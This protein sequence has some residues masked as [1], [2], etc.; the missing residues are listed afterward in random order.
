VRNQ[1]INLPVPPAINQDTVAWPSGNIL[2]DSAMTGV[3]AEAIRAALD[4]AFNENDKERP[5]NTL[6]VL[7][8]YRGQIIA[9]RYADGFNHNSMFMG[10]SMTKSI[11]NALMGIRVLDGKLKLEQAAPVAEWQNDERKNITINNL[12][13]ASSGLEW[14]ESYFVPGDFHN[15]FTSSDDK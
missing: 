13:Q 14:N 7:A 1:K 15:M 6:A 3:N 11:T 12:M 2:P 5:K 10:W 4:E 9:E 8:V